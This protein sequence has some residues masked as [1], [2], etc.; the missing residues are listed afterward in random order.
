MVGAEAGITFGQMVGAFGVL[1]TVIGVCAV[2]VAR[3]NDRTRD[4]MRVGLAK[5]ETLVAKE[6]K[7]TRD[8]LKEHM[9]NEEADRRDLRETVGGLSND[10]AQIAGHLG[11]DRTSNVRRLERGS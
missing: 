7:V 2:A 9:G 4:D 3:S 11:I 5:V 8:E 10:V 1:A 6:N